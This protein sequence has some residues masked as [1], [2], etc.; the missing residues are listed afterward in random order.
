[1]ARLPKILNALLVSVAIY[2]VVLVGVWTLVAL[3]VLAA[4]LEMPTDA[5]PL[6]YGLAFAVMTVA[7]I[8]LLGVASV[9][10]GLVAVANLIEYAQILVPGRSASPVDFVAG[11]AG[12]VFAAVLV[13]VAR[14]LMLRVH[15]EDPV[16][17]DIVVEASARPS[18][19]R[20]SDFKKG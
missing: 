7:L 17:P 14:S 15:S 9:V 10:L 6:V 13:W 20:L 2:P 8:D 16:I 11:L 3:G 12:V 19:R 4:N 1:M 18:K 5:M